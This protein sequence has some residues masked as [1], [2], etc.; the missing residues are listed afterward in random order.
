MTQEF[1]KS[2]SLTFTDNECPSESVDTTFQDDETVL[3]TIN[4]SFHQKASIKQL[5]KRIL[6][7][8]KEEDCFD[9][10]LE[11]DNYKLNKS[12]MFYI[13]FKNFIEFILQDCDDEEYV[14]SVVESMLFTEQTEI[15]H[16]L[17]ARKFDM[18][19]DSEISLAEVSRIPSNYSMSLCNCCISPEETSKRDD[20]SRDTFIN[21]Q[22]SK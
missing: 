8:V 20:Y 17:S 9:D 19:E 21:K 16:D 14:K 22:E 5:R 6:D 3:L 1:E 13:M 18:N 12:T 11:Q 15:V 7:S 2:T 10:M 4:M